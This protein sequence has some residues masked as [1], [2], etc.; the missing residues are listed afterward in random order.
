MTLAKLVKRC[1]SLLLR[2]VRNLG[3]HLIVSQETPRE[4]W[5]SFVQGSFKVRC[6]EVLDQV[7]VPESE[8]TQTH[9]GVSKLS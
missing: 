8:K 6:T 3:E 9:S 7:E 2:M 1:Q 4:L 5:R